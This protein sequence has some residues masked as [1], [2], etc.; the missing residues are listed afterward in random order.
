MGTSTVMIAGRPGCGSVSWASRL[1]P[2]AGEGTEVT[3]RG[4]RLLAVRC[5]LA[6]LRASSR[7]RS[8]ASDRMVDAPFSRRV[9][10]G[11]RPG[12]G[13]TKKRS[14]TWSHAREREIDEGHIPSCQLAFARDGQFVEWLTF[15]DA[16]PES[17]YVIFSATKPVVAAVIWILMGEGAIDVIAPRCR[18]HPRVRDQRQGRDHDR[19]GHAAHVGVPARAVLAAR[20]GR[21]RAPA[22]AVREVAVQLGAGHALRVPPDLG[23]LGARRADRAGVGI[24]LPRLRPRRV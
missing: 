7:S 8:L 11:V 18:A 20:L 4:Q 13:S 14:P 9:S 10:A 19:A 16:A 5:R 12:S 21:S 23:A 17:R 6:G 24:G 22:G 3:G 2:V 1:R 15:G